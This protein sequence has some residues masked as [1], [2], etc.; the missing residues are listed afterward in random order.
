MALATG[1]LQAHGLGPAGQHVSTWSLHATLLPQDC[2]FLD[3]NSDLSCIVLF[4]ACIEGVVL[5]DKYVGFLL[6]EMTVVGIVFPEGDFS[7]EIKLP[8]GLTVVHKLNALIRG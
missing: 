6:H 2:L 1:L 8:P 4:G 5:R 7:F 3:F